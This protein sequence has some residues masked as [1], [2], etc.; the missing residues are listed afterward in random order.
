MYSSGYGS[1]APRAFLPHS[2]INL[3]VKTPE[4]LAPSVQTSL[5]LTVTSDGSQ[6]MIAADHSTNTTTSSSCSY[7]P[8]SINQTNSTPSPQLL[9]LTR[10]LGGSTV[11]TSVP[12]S[13]ASVTPVTSVNG[14]SVK[15]DQEEPVDFSSSQQ[16]AFEA[17]AAARTTVEDSLARYKAQSK[18]KLY[19]NVAIL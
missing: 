4:L 2:A 18:L 13:T 8:A 14:K 10:P 12:N 19:P 7:N 11:A 5:D 9:D 17:A 16:L 6:Y 3:S 1:S 15:S